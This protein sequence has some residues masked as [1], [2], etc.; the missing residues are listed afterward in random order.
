MNLRWVLVCFLSLITPALA[1]D[2][3]PWFGSEASAAQHIAAQKQAQLTPQSD[4][5]ATLEC[6]IE[7]C[8]AP[9]PTAK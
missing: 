2:V 6:P 3:S 7:G 9:T 5:Q 1:E 4:Q 8:P